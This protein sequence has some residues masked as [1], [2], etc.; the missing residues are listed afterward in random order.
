MR[1]DIKIPLKAGNII[2]LAG[3]TKL[4]GN[5]RNGIFCG[6]QNS[7]G[8]FKLCFRDKLVQA[9]ARVFFKFSANVGMGISSGRYK[10]LDAL[11][12]RRIPLDA[13]DKVDNPSGVMVEGFQG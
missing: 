4:I 2:A 6:C 11:F 3:K 5:I 8:V 7:G 10:I 1:G 13:V 9:F 12:I